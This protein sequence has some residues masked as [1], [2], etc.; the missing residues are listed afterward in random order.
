MWL[1]GLNLNQS[2]DYQAWS[3]SLDHVN[4]QGNLNEASSGDLR[5]V[6]YARLG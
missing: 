1:R 3:V 6:A 2:P 5:K 4:R